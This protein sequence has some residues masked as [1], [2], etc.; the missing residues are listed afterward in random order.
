VTRLRTLGLLGVLPLYVA[1]AT[2]VGFVDYHVRRLPEHAFKVYVPTVIDGTADAPARYRVLAPHVYSAVARWTGLDA[3]DAWIVFRWLCLLATLLAGHVYLRTFFDVGPTV[4]GTALVGVLLPLT[5]THSWAHPDHLAE[6]ALFTLGCA[7][8]ARNWRV[9]FLIVLALAALNRETAVFLVPLFVLALPLSQRHLM[10]S[11]AAGLVWVAV[12][13]GLRWRLGWVS[14]D[15]WHFSENLQFLRSS[16]RVELGPDGIPFRDL[17]YRLFPWFFVPLLV[18]AWA[19]I[20]RTWTVQS[21]FSRVAAGVIA[22]ALF[23][24]GFLCSS[25]IEPRI[26]TPLIPLV[27]PG[28][29]LALFKGENRM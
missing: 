10:W 27:L 29:V 8:V 22:P 7:C 13:V 4:A 14:Y 16:W 6:A 19:L 17:Y 5:F 25:I 3:R 21:R 12:Y 15:P 24:V 28:V 18:P 11:A 23:V 2:S 1:I 9:L 20:A 26:F